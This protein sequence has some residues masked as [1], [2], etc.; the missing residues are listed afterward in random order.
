MGIDCGVIILQKACK[1]NNDQVE[2][3]K[4]DLNIQDEEEFND[5]DRPVDGTDGF[6]YLHTHYTYKGSILYYLYIGEF[7]DISVYNPSEEST[8]IDT[9]VSYDDEAELINF[10]K[11]LDGSED[12]ECQTYVLPYM[13]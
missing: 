4:Y 9:F 11:Q 5:Y 6:I 1:L 7:Y 3:L 8:T 13:D 12:C 10:V 2:A